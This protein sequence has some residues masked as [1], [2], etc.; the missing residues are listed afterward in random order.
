MHSYSNVLQM[1][2]LRCCTQVVNV[3]ALH[4]TAIVAR[5]YQHCVSCAGVSE[6]AA[7]PSHLRRHYEKECTEDCTQ[8]DVCSR[9]TLPL[10]QVICLIIVL[11][12]AASYFIY[13]LPM[14]AIV[15]EI[16]TVL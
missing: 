4:I 8:R 11:F 15:Y 13:L 14:Y 12:P 5:V 9:T 3:A 2:Y 16:D 1:Q 7:G 10:Q 6:L